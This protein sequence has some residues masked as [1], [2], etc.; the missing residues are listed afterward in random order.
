MQAFE[1]G[2]DVIPCPDSSDKPGSCVLDSLKWIDCRLRE[3]V[4]DV[5]FLR[6]PEKKSF[7]LGSSDVKSRGLASAS[8]P[9]NLTSA[10]RVLALASS[11]FSWV[12]TSASSSWV[13]ASA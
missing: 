7:L 4:K 11:S 12:L 5:V 10:S 3:G 13:L 8:R 9:K 1:N 6:D 2:S